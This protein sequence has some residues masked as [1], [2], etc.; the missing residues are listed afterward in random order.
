MGGSL[1]CVSAV[2]TIVQDNDR[3]GVFDSKT[4]K[5]VS[6]Y[7]FL[8]P[9]ADANPLWG[10]MNLVE[11]MQP[12]GLSEFALN[13]TTRDG[14]FSVE[15]TVTDSVRGALLLRSVTAAACPR[16]VVG[17]GRALSGCG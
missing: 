10:P 7:D 1:T 4:D 17:G 3:D 14:V 9:S 11:R 16:R 13:V 2:C 15:F 5:L 8:S 6:S 12:S